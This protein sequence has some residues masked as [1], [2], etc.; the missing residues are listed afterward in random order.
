[1]EN[2]GEY[3][4]QEEVDL[5]AEAPEE[6]PSERQKGSESSSIC[7]S[8]PPRMELGDFSSTVS[9]ITLCMATPVHLAYCI[10][11]FFFLYL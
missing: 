5:T 10:L 6:E 11:K 4:P 1:M 8:V 2:S 9:Y 3:Q 7:L